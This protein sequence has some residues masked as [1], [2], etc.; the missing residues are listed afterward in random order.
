MIFV[1]FVA[2][3]IQLSCPSPAESAKRVVRGRVGRASSSSRTAKTPPTFAGGAG[4]ARSPYIIRTAA[5]LSAFARSVNNGNSYAG[6][7]VKLGGDIDLSGS[8]WIPIGFSGKNGTQAFKGVFDGAGHTIWNMR[9][10]NIQRSS[11]GLFGALEGATISRVSLQYV[12]IAGDSNVGA[13]AAFMKKSSIKDCTVS[14]T[15]MG[16]SGVGGLVGTALEGIIQ[17]GSFSGLVRVEGTGAGGLIGTM[18]KTAIRG[19]YVTGRV[20]GNNDI[21]GIAGSVLAGDL[22]DCRTEGLV[23][24]GE[25]NVGGLIGNVIDRGDA[26]RSAFSG[27]VLG[28]EGVGGIVGRMVAG[29]ISNCNVLGSVQGKSRI[30]GIVGELADGDIRNCSSGASITEIGR[31]HV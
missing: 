8:G 18:D 13:V 25:Q 11:V 26:N 19:G 2:S 16:S 10:A 27:Q 24:E 31:A 30:G 5:Q 7:Y 22:M 17:N 15:V 14:G 20:E 3:L 9:T 28:D 21:G 1:L 6:K 23:V 29:T 4:T 12:E